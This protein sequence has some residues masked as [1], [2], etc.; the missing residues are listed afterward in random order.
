MI[1]GKIPDDIVCPK[2]RQ[3][4]NGR[5]RC[6]GNLCLVQCDE[7]YLQSIEHAFVY[8]C[9]PEAKKWVP[10]PEDKQIPWPDCEKVTNYFFRDKLRTKFIFS[11]SFSM[12]YNKKILIERF[13]HDG[14]VP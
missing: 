13:I 4:A 11:L 12:A 7:G 8:R 14:L 5:T 9:M 2:F 3:P 6:A 1:S 10:L